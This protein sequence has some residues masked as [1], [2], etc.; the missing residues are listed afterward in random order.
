MDD[1]TKHWSSLSLSDR[2]GSGLRLKKEQA[3]NEFIIAAR[4]FTKRS[5]NIDAIAR[6]FSPLWRSKA[7]FNIKNNGDHIILFSFDN[8]LE[9]DRILSSEPWCFDKHLM[10]LSKIKKGSPL[11]ECNFNR[12]SF[13][14][15][16][17]D[18]PL[19]YRNKEVAKQIC[20]TIGVIQ[21][22]KDPPDCDGGSFIRVRVSIDISLPLCRGR[23][24]TLDDDKEHWVSFK[25]KR[26]PNLCYWCGWLTHTDKDCEKWID[27]EG[28]LQPD[29]QQFGAW[30]RAPSFVA[31]RKNV[32]AVPSFFAKKKTETP[33]QNATARP[34]HPHGRSHPMV[35]EPANHHSMTINEPCAN[36]A[37]HAI[38]GGTTTAS[39]ISN[40]TDSDPS[41]KPTLQADF[42]HLIREID[43]D[44]HLFYSGNLQARLSKENKREQIIEA[45]SQPSA[46]S[47]PNTDQN[48][49]QPIQPI[50]LNDITNQ[51]PSI[52]STQAQAGKKWARIQR[53]P[54]ISESQELNLIL[55]KRSS[56]PL[57]DYTFSPKCKAIEAP[58]SDENL[59]PTVAADLQPRRQT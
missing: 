37:S 2:E 15:Q 3:V 9:V 30:M 55:G 18:I 20:E 10:V 53:P 50:P 1:L 22:P 49:V 5:L 33:V 48:Q 38:P 42:E 8:E 25:Y 24:I 23:L 17:Y 31:S 56:H 58:L 26:L 46:H 45:N 35:S 21:H 44:I 47:S 57:P 28:S 11:K 59:L 34:P 51:D 41:R 14:V 40:L 36:L 12:A 19:R 29:D 6:T 43:K 39:A 16:V 13:W 4:F 32:V 7:G 52:S 54:I 27:S